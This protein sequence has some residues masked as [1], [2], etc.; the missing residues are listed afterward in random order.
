MPAPVL[1]MSSPRWLLA[2][3]LRWSAPS[4]LF[5]IRKSPVN[6]TGGGITPARAPESPLLAERDDS[7]DLSFGFV[8]HWAANGDSFT[9]GIGSGSQRG[10]PPAKAADWFCSRFTYTWPQIVD[11]YIG[12]TKK[13]FLLGVMEWHREV[14]M[15]LVCGVMCVLKGRKP[16]ATTCVWEA[17]HK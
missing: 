7:S 16:G 17:I 5:V 15:E 11:R 13:D 4:T 6:S 10:H 1:T 9:A 8:Q 12:P 2:V 14:V 3:I